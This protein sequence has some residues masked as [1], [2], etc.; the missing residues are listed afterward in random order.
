DLL[1]R[2][3][4]ADL[5]PFLLPSSPGLSGRS[6]FFVFFSTERKKKRGCHAFAWHDGGRDGRTQ[7]RGRGGES[8][9]HIAPVFR[10]TPSHGLHRSGSRRPA[11]YPPRHARRAGVG[12]GGGAGAAWAGRV[13][14]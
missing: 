5:Y 11:R 9:S 7:A 4:G 3:E 13:V 12:G 6:T 1:I 2:L 10:Y 14:A 8:G